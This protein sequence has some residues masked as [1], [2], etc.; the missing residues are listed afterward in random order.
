[1]HDP[2]S[3]G[4]NTDHSY[5]VYYTHGWKNEQQDAEDGG[6]QAGQDHRS[7]SRNFVPELN[8]SHDLENAHDDCPGNNEIHQ[9]DH[10]DARPEECQETE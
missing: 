9:D 10:S 6:E 2:T 7:F 1:L 4:V 5:Q 8:G 3:D